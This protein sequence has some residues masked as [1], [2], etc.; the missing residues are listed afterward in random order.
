MIVRVAK[1]LQPDGTELEFHP[2]VRI[3]KD[4]LVVGLN[5]GPVR[6]LLRI[7]D[8]YGGPSLWPL[9]MFEVISPHIPSSW[10][11]G[12][13]SI[14]E[15][16]YLT[17]GPSVWARKSFWD[18]YFDDEPRAVADYTNE[19]ERMLTEDRRRE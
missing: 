6:R 13:G 4:Y 18:E 15:A 2:A 9:E 16:T 1:I 7:H 8:D 11:A 17:V 14:D 19:V 10:N 3:G 12:I 5:I